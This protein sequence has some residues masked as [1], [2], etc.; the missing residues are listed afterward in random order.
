[1]ISPLCCFNDCGLDKG[2]GEGGYSSWFLR[3]C[4]WRP[5]ANSAF[6]SATGELFY[7]PQSNWVFKDKAKKKKLKKKI[8]EAAFFWRFF[9]SSSSMTL[10]N[11]SAPLS[12]E[13]GSACELKQWIA[14]TAFLCRRANGTQTKLP[15]LARHFKMTISIRPT[16]SDKTLAS[17]G[18]TSE[19]A[20]ICLRCDI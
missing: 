1:M 8:F 6:I 13:F 18:V 3:L 17:Y 16:H 7:F 4:L 19:G 9:F 12:V 15:W 5:L 11:Y 14:Y 20:I 2:G 10:H